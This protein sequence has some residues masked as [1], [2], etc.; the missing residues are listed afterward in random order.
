MDIIE[1]AWFRSAN[2]YDDTGI[3]TGDVEPV[4]CDEHYRERLIIIDRISSMRLYIYE[5]SIYSR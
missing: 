5:M 3:Q 2:G 4:F 1:E